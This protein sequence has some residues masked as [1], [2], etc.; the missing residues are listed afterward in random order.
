M[1]RFTPAPPV[2]PVEESAA[3]PGTVTIVLRGER[4]TVPRRCG[5]TL[6]QSA[7]RAGL[8]PPFSCEAGDCA[9]CMARVTEGEAKMR[10]NNALEED[11]VAE[12]YVLTCQGEPVS[13]HLTVDYEA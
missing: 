3:D 5:E 11:E 4:R 9:T 8:T 7:R 2:P 6:L 1:E 12:G 10:V 13:P